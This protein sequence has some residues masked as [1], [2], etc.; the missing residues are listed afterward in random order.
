MFSWQPPSGY[1]NN[2]WLSL[3]SIFMI[4]LRMI[5]TA[6]EMHLFCLDLT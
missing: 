1:H 4:N 5:D 3:V 2:E 6:L